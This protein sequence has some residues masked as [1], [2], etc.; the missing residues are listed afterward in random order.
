MRDMMRIG[1]QI[2]TSR[3]PAKKINN[4]LAQFGLRHRNHFTFLDTVFSH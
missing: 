3:G 2:D 1:V 4:A